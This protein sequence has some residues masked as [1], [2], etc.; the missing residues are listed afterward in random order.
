MALN[1]AKSPLVGPVIALNGWTLFME[2][3]MYIRR[4]P[5]INKAVAQGK[6]STGPTMTKESKLHLKSTLA[7]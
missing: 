5:A 1:I 3:W 2:V 7:T 6:L 4:I